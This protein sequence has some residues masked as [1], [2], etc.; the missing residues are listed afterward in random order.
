VNRVLNAFSPETPKL[1]LSLGYSSFLEW[2]FIK[3]AANY[4]VLNK[5]VLI[6]TIRGNNYPEE[7]RSLQVGTGPYTAYQVIAVDAGGRES[8]ASEPLET[9]PDDKTNIQVVQLETFAPKAAQAYQGYT[10]QGF[11]EIS[12]THNTTLA[13]PVEAPETGLY[14]VDFRYANGNGPVNTE[15]K[16]AIR[17]LRRGQQQL[18]TVVLPQRGTGEWSNWG[19]SNAVLVRLDQ[20]PHTLTLALEAANENMNGAVNQAM[21]DHLRLT[22]V[23]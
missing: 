12:K 20:G 13:I 5:G 10:G 1:G 21:L 8:F 18:G 16:C 19:Y 17:T 22:R 2:D 3:D 9:G 4:K 15:N 11:V 7:G 6:A 14:A 23:Q